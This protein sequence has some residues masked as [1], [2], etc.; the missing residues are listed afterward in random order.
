MENIRKNV[1]HHWLQ[2][3]FVIVV[4]WF[5]VAFLLFPSF[6]ILKD[7]FVSDGSFSLETVSR[8]FDSN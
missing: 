4:I 8:V 5:A 6:S 2:Y 1:S 3:L 7:T